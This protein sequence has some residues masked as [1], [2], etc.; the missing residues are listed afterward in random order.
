MHPD[1]RRAFAEHALELL[2]PIGPCVARRLFG[3]WGLSTGG[4]TVAIITDLGGGD[5]LW[6]KAGSDT[7]AAFEAAG[8]ARFTYTARGRPRGLDY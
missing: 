8:C 3:G 5:T 1:P 4:L 7:R 2:A 6:L